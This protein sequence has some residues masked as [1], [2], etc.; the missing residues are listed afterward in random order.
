MT[1]VLCFGTGLESDVVLPV[2]VV[3]ITCSVVLPVLLALLFLSLGRIKDVDVTERKDRMGLFLVVMAVQIIGAFITF[4]FPVTL[5]FR[6]LVVLELIIFC[7]ASVITN[8]YKISIHA[9]S[10]TTLYLV[11]GYVTGY[12]YWWTFSVIIIVCWARLRLNKH[13]L[14]QLVLGCAVPL[15]VFLTGLLTV[16]E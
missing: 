8:Y 10:A 1:L 3:L 6:Q 15:V 11:F 7:I 13:T 2:G 16:L 5:I 9:L 12:R 4:T 14:M